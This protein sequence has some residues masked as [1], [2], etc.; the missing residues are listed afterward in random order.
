[1]N[2]E[3]YRDFDQDFLFREL[4]ISSDKNSALISDCSSL[5]ESAIQ[6]DTPAVT[7]PTRQF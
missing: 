3:W 2:D 4:L 5:I 1:M 6:K 7:T